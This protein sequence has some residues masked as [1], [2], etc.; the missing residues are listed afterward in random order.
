M[1][2]S[3]ATR[4]DEAEGLAELFACVKEVVRT[5]LG[6]SRTGIMVGLT[7]LGFSP[8][9][10]VGGYFVTGTNA[11]VLNRDL[12]NYVRAKAPGM[13]N[14]LAFQLL[15]HEYLHTLGYLSEHQVRPMVHELSKEALG[16]DHAATRL[17]EAML[18]GADPRGLPELVRDVV[19]PRFG[20]RPSGDPAFE[21]VPGVDP[22]AS[23]YIQ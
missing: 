3:L 1:D 16:P 19:L 23:P 6:R 21:I 13:H 22:E 2:R 12:L 5:H 11:I 9:G 8:Q 10:Y 20:W 17:A 18:P 4:I 14:A 7:S 15:L